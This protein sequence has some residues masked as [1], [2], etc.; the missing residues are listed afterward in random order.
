MLTFDEFKNEVI[1]AMSG[2]PNGWRDGQFVF[3]YIDEV[4]GVAR[5][6]QF[7]Y[8]VDCFYDDSKIDAFI[9]KAYD[10]YVRMEEL[11]DDYGFGVDYNALYE[12]QKNKELEF[13]RKFIDY[14]AYD[15][16][17][18]KDYILEMISTNEYNEYLGD[19]DGEWVIKDGKPHIS[20]EIEG[21]KLTAEW[22]VED[23]YAVWQQNISMGGD[24]YQG[25][26]LLPKAFK[27]YFV[28]KYK[29]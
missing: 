22:F 14:M 10:E 28:I 18:N 20:I 21:S 15:C 1:H 4:Y 17:G 5:N 11:Y 24:S 23:N 6:I 19:F 29:C 3:N 9:E 7:G 16:I 26:L 2:K 8:G 12:D 25:Y 13:Y 27:K